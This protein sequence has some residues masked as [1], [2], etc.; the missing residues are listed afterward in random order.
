MK[1]I[2]LIFSNRKV[3]K[4]NK[5]YITME[6]TKILIP[7][8]FQVEAL[9]AL[10]ETKQKGGVVVLPTGT[11]KTFLASMWFKTKLDKEPNAK[12]LFVCHNKDILSQANENEFQIRLKDMNIDYGYYNAKQKDIRQCTFATVQTL[13]RNL[14]KFDSSYFDYIIVDEAHHY[15][16]KSFK[17]VLEYFSP[18]FMLGL[19]ATPNRKDNKNI[20][21]LIGD[22]IYEAKIHDAIKLGLLSKIN[23]WCVDNDI[24]FSK[25]KYNGTSYD[26]ADLN[27]KICI[28]EYDESILFEYQ[29]T[30]K[31][32]FLKTKTICFCATVEHVHR[33]TAL[34]NNFG[35]SAVGLTGKNRLVDDKLPR[36]DREKVIL[37]F[38]K[39][40]YDIIFVRDLFNEGVDIPDC[41]SIMMLRPTQ[42]NIIFTQQLGRGLRKSKDKEDVLILDFTGNA[43]NC[44][45]NFEVLSSMI[46]IN[47]KDDVVKKNTNNKLNEISI[48][49]IGCTVRLNKHKVDVLLAEL[50]NVHLTLHQSIKKY[51]SIYQTKPTRGELAIN[52]TS[53]YEHFR[54]HKLLDKYCLQST[55]LTLQQTTK[56]YHSIYQTK[57]TRGELAIQYPAI[58]SQFKQNSLLDKYCQK[59][60][61][62]NLKQSIK[63]YTEIYK[64]KPTRGKLDKENPNIYAHFVKNKLLDK[65]CQQAVNL[66]LKQTIKKYNEIYKIKPTKRKLEQENVQIYSQFSRNKLLDKYCQSSIYMNLEKAI[67]KYNM[68]YKTK[69][70]RRKL[71]EDN[72]AIYEHFSR[73]KLLDK[74]CQKSTQLNL[75][76]TIKK[77]TEIYKTK[78]AR[79][80]LYRQ[81]VA[82]YS[83]FLKNNL[84]D[85]YCQPA[86]KRGR[87][88]VKDNIKIIESYKP[89]NIIIKKLTK[90]RSKKDKRPALK[91]KN[92]EYHSKEDKIDI[93]SKII[94]N[95]NNDDVVLMLESPDLLAIK[96]I[97]KQSKKPLKIVIPNNKQFKELATKLNAYDTDLN[98][99]LI[100]TSILQYLLDTNDK[101]DFVWMDYCGA[102]SCYTQDLDVLFNQLM[103]DIKLVVTYNTMDLDKDDDSYYFVNVIDYILEKLNDEYQVRLIKD[104]S[105][106]YKK[107]MYNVGFDISILSSKS[108]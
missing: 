83:H 17:K 14:N 21:E 99:E 11:G 32:K 93:R 80:E 44:S 13:S 54:R 1:F 38:K 10:N 65:Y 12:M 27:K 101:F 19:T 3:Y 4:H 61:Q 66:N 2:N 69:P 57:P 106:R 77:Y 87:K 108:I 70:T 81:N 31:E 23:Y 30:L 96:E 46:D 53:I 102:F 89:K 5:L 20:F 8:I 7:N 76:Q 74:Y 63:K 26:I 36:R 103:T 98:I 45:I 72:Q 85:K 55:Q 92:V 60:A 105:Y 79:D 94:R 29:K 43:K 56:K 41:D 88:P 24:D 52:H 100:N 35:Y 6:N 73:H 22:K 84:L 62:L 49:S 34:F 104:I 78:P 86:K 48:S 51:H 16:A 75:K 107:N 64:T 25:I 95:I 9:K 67:C 82:I 47:I 50:T 97:E 68:L 59:S 40:K 33:M 37:E 71:H 18:I 28:E 39:G 15:Q 91:L 42:S 90:H 58:Y